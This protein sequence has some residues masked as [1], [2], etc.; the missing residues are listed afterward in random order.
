M[1]EALKSGD[2]GSDDS[3]GDMNEDDFSDDVDVD[4]IDNFINENEDMLEKNDQ[5]MFTEE[6]DSED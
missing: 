6:D 1:L 2:S 5:I 4:D 3:N